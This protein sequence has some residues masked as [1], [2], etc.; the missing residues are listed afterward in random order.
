M[1][2]RVQKNNRSPITRPVSSQR[3]NPLNVPRRLDIQNASS[4]LANGLTTSSVLIVEAKRLLKE[5]VRVRAAANQ[6]DSILL[7]DTLA[8]TCVLIAEAQKLRK[9]T[10]KVRSIAKR[11]QARSRKARKTPLLSA[12]PICGE[13]PGERRNRELRELAERG[14]PVLHISKW[15]SRVGPLILWPHAGRWLNEETGKRG[16]M[17]SSSMQ[18]LILNEGS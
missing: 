11:I 8:R 16:K 5:V 12:W 13:S 4:C 15:Q 7:A 1:V 18:Q 6:N 17:N 14:F 10:V 3:A 2:L 9:E